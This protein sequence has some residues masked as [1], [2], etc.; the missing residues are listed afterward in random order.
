MMVAPV[1]I[2]ASITPGM[3]MGSDWVAGRSRNGVTPFS[4][5]KAEAFMSR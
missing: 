2:A 1:E 3:R 4:K 5:P